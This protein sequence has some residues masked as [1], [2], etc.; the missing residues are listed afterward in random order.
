MF[1]K[2]LRERRGSVLT[3][4]AIAA[5]PLISA[6]GAA[7]DYSRAFHERTVVQ[8]ALDSA[9]LAAGKKIG[10]LTNEQIQTEANGFYLANIGDKLTSPPALSTVVATST[11]TGSAEL[12]VPTYFLGIIGLNEIVFDVKATA[13][14]AMGT[15]EVAM[16]LDNSG[17]MAGSKISTLTDR[18]HKSRHDALW[19]WYHQHRA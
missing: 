10:L 19:P 17:S 1:K 12:H 16:V 4:F 8:D 7:V 18:R 2:F 13:T 15:L 11:L 5:I 6:M 3:T 9:V 14:L